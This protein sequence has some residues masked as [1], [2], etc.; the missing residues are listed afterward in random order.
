[1]ANVC[2]RPTT[3]KEG[4]PKQKELRMGDE[5]RG[6]QHREGEEGGSDDASS[7]SMRSLLEEASKMLKSLEH[8]GP[9]SPSSTVLR[10]DE[11]KGDVMRNLQA[12]LSSLKASQ[13]VFKMK[14]IGCGRDHGLIDSG[15]THALRW[16]RPE[17][18]DDLRK[19]EVTLADGSTVEMMMTRGGVM[20]TDDSQVEP[21]V[22]MG[23]LTGALKCEV[24]WKGEEI[25][26]VHPVRGRI[27]VTQRDG[28]PQLSKKEDEDEAK[29]LLRRRVE[30]L[31]E[32]EG[33]RMFEDD[34]EVAEEELKILR[35]LKRFTAPQEEEEVLQ[36]KIVSPKEVS[37][38]WSDWIDSVKSEVESLTEEKEA[39]KPLTPEEVKRK[40][41]EAEARGQKVEYIP[42]KVI[43]T[44]KPGK[45]GGKKKTRWVVCKNYEEKKEGEDTFSSGVDATAFR[46]L[47]W[48]GC[49]RGWPF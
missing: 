15:A 8:S 42:S 9:S 38:N 22:P 6:T 17:E 33:K 35:K 43:F 47:I 48:I 13:K 36:T 19:V 27:P 28:C 44:R 11:E 34:L 49:R 14:K 2:T 46:V 30:E 16:R 31:I 32:E 3:S 18:E 23:S 39:L 45:Q 41:E 4:S 40:V 1:M 10:E 29:R 12:Q 21:I 7:T 20:L 26:V 5:R 25:E 24:K 37:A